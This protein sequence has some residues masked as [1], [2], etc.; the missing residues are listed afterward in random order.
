M[1]IPE[2]DAEVPPLVPVRSGHSA[3]CIRALEVVKQTQARVGDPV[4]IA[5]PDADSAVLTLEN[6]VAR[7]GKIEVLHSINLTLD[8]HECLAVVGESGSGKTTTAR[9]IAGLH[10][11]WTGSI[12]LGDKELETAARS[13]STETRRQIQYIF[14][15]PY[16]SLNPRKTV[17]ET[18]GQPLAVFGLAKGREAE[19]RV[20]EMLEQVSL[21]ASYANRFPD[22]LSGGER[23][24]VAIAR[25]LI[26]SP[27]I[28]VC[29]EVTSALD[30]SVQAAI[31]ELLGQLQR[32]LG[33]SMV[34]VTHNLPLVRSIA[35]KVAVL[36][37]GSIVEYGETAQMLADPQQ[38]YT[39]QLIA[40]TPSLELA[41]AEAH[42]EQGLH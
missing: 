34:F 21:S 41:T 13:R 24:R 11:D 12:R 16:G 15:N 42:I 1:Y 8:Q 22:Q 31:V 4:D 35:Q 39:Q 20:G 5:H 28:L 6:V 38:P 27:S 32:D 2:C 25:G 14:Q 29:D 30:V 18:V 3:R 9:S 37:E 7:Y 17:G 36:S 23:Q 26:S 10:R 40:N 33:L 19:D